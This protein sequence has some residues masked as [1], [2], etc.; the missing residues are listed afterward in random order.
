[1]L[2]P[3]AGATMKSDKDVQRA[4]G[5]SQL[6]PDVFNL[7]PEPCG[8]TL[9]LSALPA[10]QHSVHRLEMKHGRGRGAS[11]TFPMPWICAICEADPLPRALPNLCL[12][13]VPVCGALISQWARAVQTGSLPRAQLPGLPWIDSSNVQPRSWFGGS[14]RQ[15]LF[16]LVRPCSL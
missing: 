10:Q 6:L 9:L 7:P 3:T 11:N 4:E 2:F 5:C 14:I 13:K 12:G 15:P 16:C 8:W 1:M